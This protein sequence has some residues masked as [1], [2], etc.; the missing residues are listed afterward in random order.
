MCCNFPCP[1]LTKR[2][3]LVIQRWMNRRI[4]LKLHC[5]YK[6][7]CKE[8]TEGLVILGHLHKLL[9]RSSLDFLET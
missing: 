9:F 5:R 1:A 8:A 7:F 4:S 3:R 2:N 6:C